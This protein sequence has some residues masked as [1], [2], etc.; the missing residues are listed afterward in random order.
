MTKTKTELRES[1][2]LLENELRAMSVAGHT[3]KE[4]LD[5]VVY[6][7]IR[8]GREVTPR[9]RADLFEE[10]ERVVPGS[11][12]DLAADQQPAKLRQR[13]GPA[14][15]DDGPSR[16]RSAHRAPGCVHPCKLCEQQQR[17]GKS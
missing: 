4:R 16:L 9:L 14:R 6:M 1:A 2:E 13:L 17:G 11:T 15:V 8:T 10:L 7:L 12:R 3:L 5:T